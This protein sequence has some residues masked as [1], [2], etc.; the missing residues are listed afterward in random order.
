MDVRRAPEIPEH[1]RP[2]DLPDVPD[3]IAADVIIFRKGHVQVIHAT[4]GDQFHGL[5][6]IG[7]PVRGQQIH[8]HFFHEIFLVS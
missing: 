2:F 4:G 6:G 7:F 5:T 3:T 1:V 8:Q